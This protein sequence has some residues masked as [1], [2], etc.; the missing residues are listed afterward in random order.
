MA[1]E[2]C[3]GG[4]TYTGVKYMRTVT[5]RKPALTE[6]GTHTWTVHYRDGSTRDYTGGRNEE[7]A[8]TREAATTAGTITHRFDPADQEA[9]ND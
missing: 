5:P 9:T 1:C 4:Y 8:A 2:P 7:A 3:G 6:A